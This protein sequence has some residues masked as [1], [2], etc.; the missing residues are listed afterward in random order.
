MEEKTNFPLEFLKKKIMVPQIPPE[1]SLPFPLIH[2][3][4]L[5]IDAKIVVFIQGT[6]SRSGSCRSWEHWNP[7]RGWAWCPVM[8]I[9]RWPKPHR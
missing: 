6:C 5:L 8:R 4:L 9:Y 1:L 3:R 7:W 2:L